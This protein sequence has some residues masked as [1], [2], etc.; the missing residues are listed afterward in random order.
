MLVLFVE[1]D[2]FKS[3]G[4]SVARLCSGKERP[5]IVLSLYYV[6]LIRHSLCSSWLP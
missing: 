6:R 4:G 2:V 5:P 3:S 1:I